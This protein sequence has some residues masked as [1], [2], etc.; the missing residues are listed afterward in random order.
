[1]HDDISITAARN[2]LTALPEALEKRPGAIA[3]TRKGKPVLAILPWDLYESLT[4][5]L[6]I[7]SDPAL[8]DQLRASVGDVERGKLADWDK[9]RAELDI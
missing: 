3:V 8:M 2:R 1:M 9:V 5:T 6:E 4:E 7:V